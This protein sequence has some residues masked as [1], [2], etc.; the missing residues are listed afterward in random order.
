MPS[1]KSEQSKDMKE[2]KVRTL[3][4]IVVSDAMDKTIVVRVDR[5][6]THRLYGKRYTV[7]KR[8][9]V[10]DEKN[11][12]RTGDKVAFIECRPFS[13]EKRWRVL[14]NSEKK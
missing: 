10:H 5:T 6:K 12:Y 2:K 14:Y 4:G 1:T 9:K 13:K 11:Q 3:R 8:F 7:S